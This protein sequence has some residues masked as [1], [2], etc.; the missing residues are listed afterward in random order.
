MDPPDTSPPA[1]PAE[2]V[3]PLGPLEPAQLRRQLDPDHLAF[4]TTA[5]IDSL[6]E[7][8]GQ[9]R[10]L[11]ALDL[12]LA[13]RAP[14]YNVYV[15]GP[16]GSGR[17]TTTRD[18]VTR[19]AEDMDPPRDWV[20]VY[21]FVEPDQPAAISLSSGSGQRLA[22][23]MDEFIRSMEE[24]IPR[25]FESEEHAANR[26]K[27]LAEIAR[28]RDA[29]TNELEA[30]AKESG[31]AVQMT[32]AGFVSIPLRLGK[33]LASAE[34]ERLSAEEQAD[35][36]ERGGDV[37][38][39]VSDA[40]RVLRR[41]E[42]RAQE[43]LAVLDRD[44]VAFAA[45]PMLHDLREE[46]EGEPRV[47]AF[48]RDVERDL[49]DHIDA[50]RQT[51]TSE[52]P[53]ALRMT[54]RAETDLLA[55]YR[56][57]VL[58]THGGTAGAPV[59]LERNPTYYNLGGRIDYQATFGAMVTDLHQVKPGALQR[60][61]GGFLVL[62]AIDVLRNPFAWDSLKRSL[63]AREAHIENLAVQVSAIPTATLRPEPIPL[64]LK[65]ILIGSR[66]LYHLLCGVDEEFREL[67]KVKVDFAPDME[68]NERTV[69]YYA[70]FIARRVRENDL[71]HFDRAAVARVV[72]HGA[73]LRDDQRKLSTR[74]L[75]IADLVTEASFFASRGGAQI[76]TE[77]H[78]D[79]AVAK[80]RY[81][82]NLYEERLHELIADGTIAIS[83]VGE[84]V[85]QINGLSVL[86]L[87]DFRFGKPARVTATVSLG[88]GAVT[89]IE[90]EIELSGP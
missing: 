79:D 28:E 55:R 83:T 51:A 52:L 90:R 64:D 76:V 72:E 17:T 84:R 8:V 47:I 48:L 20:Y 23:G 31:Y 38:A 30:R 12:G 33:P 87:G 88:E 9:P 89:S 56:V 44:L 80:R 7:T 69:G 78:V 68:W 26:S 77:E 22:T 62:Q 59:I 65:V 71:L 36:E 61:N 37:Q 85:G 60:A 46:H 66:A 14:G 57:N 58:V 70:S 63:S 49:P 43:R 27:A 53:A 10:A 35:I 29:A 50:F 74:L 16:A 19:R 13:V 42:K 34:F 81:R 15:A 75:D 4:D 6:T 54:Q 45:G 86:Q 25:A 1:K 32:P 82:S 18:Y 5:E 67:F 24:A 40:V 3:A 2:I 21:N 11:S 41:L 73:R 39:H